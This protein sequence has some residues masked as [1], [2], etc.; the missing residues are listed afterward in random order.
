MKRKLNC[1]VLWLV[2]R[3]VQQYRRK[4]R[5]KGKREK[6]HGKKTRRKG[7]WFMGRNKICFLVGVDLSFLGILVHH[8]HVKSTIG[9]CRKCHYGKM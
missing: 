2:T 1:Q 8:I 4:R 5:A 6:N 7:G 9:Y 3:E